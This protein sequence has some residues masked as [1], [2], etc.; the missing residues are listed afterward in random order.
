MVVSP[1][2]S[3]HRRIEVAAGAEL[4]LRGPSTV[5]I[6]ELVIEPGA[7]L[8]L[9]TR[10]GDVALFVTEGIDLQAGSNVETTSELPDELSIQVAEIPSDGGDAPVQ[11][12][13]TSQFHGFIYAPDTEVRI[14]GDF[15]VYGGVVARRLDIGAGARL[16]FDSTGLEKSPIPRIVSWRI[17][18]IPSVVR[19]SQAAFARLARQRRVAKKLGDAHDLDHV[20]LSV[21]YLNHSGTELTYDGK[22]DDFN[23]TTVAEV[24]DVDRDPDRTRE[25]SAADA[26]RK[27]DSTGGTTTPVLPNV[28]PRVNHLIENGC[29]HGNHN[30]HYVDELV[31]K[32][33]L[34]REEWQAFYAG[35]Q[36]KDKEVERLIEEDLKAGGP[37]GPR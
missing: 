10:D 28:R 9:D 19:H 30:A 20:Q 34:S 5:V 16:H 31:T 18:E 3:G 4:I 1:G 36:P 23:W 21:R 13:A 33:P 11:L 37:G 14:G 35:P 26:T 17:I 32:L 2:T 8:T 6:G 7:Q 29:E 27:G 25:N 15:E 22:E 12:N 24:V